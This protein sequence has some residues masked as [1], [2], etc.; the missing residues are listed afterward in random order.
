MLLLIKA[1]RSIVASRSGKRTKML[2]VF[3]AFEFTAKYA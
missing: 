3:G 1:V 2:V